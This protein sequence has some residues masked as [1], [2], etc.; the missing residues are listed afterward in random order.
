MNKKEYLRQMAGSKLNDGQTEEAIDLFDEMLHTYDP[1]LWPYVTVVCLC[2]VIILFTLVGCGGEAVEYQKATDPAHLMSA[3][4][5]TVV[6][7]G[8][9]ADS[10]QQKKL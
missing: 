2:V 1:P 10:S 3:Q 8:Q 5:T 4:K 9:H 7:R 6:E